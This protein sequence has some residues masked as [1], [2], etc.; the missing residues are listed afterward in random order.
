[1]SEMGN[2]GSRRRAS[3]GKNPDFN[4]TAPENLSPRKKKTPEA[5]TQSTDER[6]ANFKE[7]RA[8]FGDGGGKK[9]TGNFKSQDK[10]VVGEGVNLRKTSNDAKKMDSNQ[11]V[12]SSAMRDKTAVAKSATSVPRPPKQV[13]APQDMPKEKT[14]EDYSSLKEARAAGQTYYSKDGKKM[15]AV[16]ASDLKEGQSLT[17]YM[18]S[19]QRGKVEKPAKKMMAGGTAKAYKEGG[20][21]RGVG[22]AKKGVRSCKMR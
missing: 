5:N 9:S 11:D 13:K 10:K 20:T 3:R 4:M 14:W 8:K 1:M 6:Y 7:R 22:M 2:S 15:A 12:K 21:V 19:K 16:L 18:N 17:D